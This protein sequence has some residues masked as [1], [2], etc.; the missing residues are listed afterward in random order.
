MGRV[1]TNVFRPR[2]ARRGMEMQFLKSDTMGTGGTTITGSATTTVPICSPYMRG[3]V[4]S[5]SIRA[6]V[7]PVSAS[8]TVLLTVYKW[9]A[10]NGAAVALNTAFSCES[11]GITAVKT[12]IVIPVLSTLTTAQR[13]KLEADTFYLSIVS[14]NSIGT[15]PTNMQLVLAVAQ[16]R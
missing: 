13:T 7:V 5:I 6:D 12:N 8:G 16:T 4:D 15:A 11:D 3:W 9:D 1:Y 2:S 10:A 14:N